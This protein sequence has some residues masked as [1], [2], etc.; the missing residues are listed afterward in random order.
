MTLEERISRYLDGGLGAEQVA[1]LDVLLRDS[2]E[3]RET[4]REIAATHVLLDQAHEE[5]S[6]ADW[7]E[8]VQPRKIVFRWL[9]AAAAAA[10]A[11]AVTWWVVNLQSEPS[12]TVVATA[13]GGTGVLE[14]GPL[15]L[16]VGET[17]EITF[18]KG[19][20]VALQ[21]PLEIELVSDERMKLVQ[22]KIGVEVPEGAEG[23]TVETPEGEVIDYGTRFGL[24]VDEDGDMRAEVFQGRI[25]VVIGEKTHR[26]EGQASLDVSG[27]DQSLVSGS[28]SSAFPMPSFKELWQIG[29][30][31]D[32]EKNYP[33]GRPTSVNQ[34][35]GDL[36]KVVSSFQEVV[37]RSGRGM[38]QFKGTS[39]QTDVR[40]TVA[41]QLWRIID[42]YEVREK[43]GRRPEQVNLSG[44]VNRVAGNRQSDR[45]FLF[46][47]SCH[48]EITGDLDEEED[49]VAKVTTALASD[50]DPE[51]W[52][53]ADLQ[54]HLPQNL[55]YLVIMVGAREDR[56]NDEDDQE[57]D[58]HFLDKLDLVFHA[59]M[60]PSIERHH[61]RGSE[62]DWKDPGKWS[63]NRL[64]S[65]DSCTV[66]QGAGQATLRGDIHQESGSFIVALDNESEGS[67]YLPPMATLNLGS[68]ETIIGFNR[69]ALAD[70]QISGKLITDNRLFIGRNNQRSSVIV[71]G[72]ILST[73]HIQL[74]QYDSP[75]DTLAELAIEG[76]TVKAHSL[77]LVNDMAKVTLNG[78]ELT[79][80][81]LHLGGDNGTA[82]FYHQRGVVRIEK[83]ILNG[84]QYHLNE[85]PNVQIWIKMPAGQLTE[86]LPG[87]PRETEGDWTLISHSQ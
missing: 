76:G 18:L 56:F 55:R 10:F 58:G 75:E 26:M 81:E 21:G 41:S 86:F 4:Y 77:K 43:M 42:L 72:S 11:I 12:S 29:G 63:E 20:R 73:N 65:P 87:V 36:V 25:D 45:A 50:A 59:G 79:V 24:A 60:R 54:L 62:G 7:A 52:E 85:G 13:A 37:P 51:T 16:A 83:L 68:T 70:V 15:S 44:W 66:I 19:A 71:T 8:P 6:G 2:A 80:K 53:R 34:W 5:E 38:L 9:P 78:G 30:G 1:E 22:G 61:W 23:F 14:A 33:G 3:A 69:G 27:N 48:E 64:P 32:G 35:S 84:G 49:V 17:R 74:S 82:D 46:S 67:V 47:L 28:D 40:E 57:F 39:A 31:F